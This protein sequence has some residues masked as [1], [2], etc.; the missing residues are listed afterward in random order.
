[1]VLPYAAKQGGPRHSMSAAVNALSAL[2]SMS[3]NVTGGLSNIKQRE[4]VKQTAAK[5]RS[6][7]IPSGK[8]ARKSMS[9]IDSKNKEDTLTPKDFHV[10]SGASPNKASRKSMVT[11]I[12]S[13]MNEDT[14]QYQDNLN[15]IK[16]AQDVISLLKNQNISLKD[17]ITI[18][19]SEREIINHLTKVNKMG[20]KV[21]QI[22]H[23]NF[24]SIYLADVTSYFSLFF[25]SFGRFCDEQYALGKEYSAC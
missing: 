9:L 8:L 22:D 12:G 1:M 7:V 16:E 24:L 2:H 15:G 25:F 4:F 17:K 20:K 21:A 5:R 19:R 10:L 11:A 3:T 6:S 14:L 23:H 13:V 18:L